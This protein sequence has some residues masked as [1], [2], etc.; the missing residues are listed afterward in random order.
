MVIQKVPKSIAAPDEEAS[1]LAHKLYQ[2]LLACVESIDANF[3]SMSRIIFKFISEPRLVEA[4]GWED[5]RE[6][7]QQPEIR[8]HVERMKINSPAQFYRWQQAARLDA[9]RPDLH[10]LKLEKLSSAVQKGK[11]KA[12][13]EVIEKNLPKEEELDEITAILGEEPPE[14]ELLMSKD[15]TLNLKTMTGSWKG[16]AAIRFIGGVGAIKLMARLLPHYRF[17]YYP[18]ESSVVGFYD[19]DGKK[20]AVVLSTDTEWLDYLQ[21]RLR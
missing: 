15:F 21:K 11:L 8:Q 16:K 1:V 13:E 12:L 17:K 19:D 14:R 3:E 2:E 18:D 20:E 9:K 6:I 7:F 10:I 4:M 5:P